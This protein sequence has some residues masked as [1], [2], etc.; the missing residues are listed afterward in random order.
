LVSVDGPTRGRQMRSMR[1]RS[2][3]TTSRR[4]CTKASKNTLRPGPT[5]A[6]RVVA[7][8][9]MSR[10]MVA[11]V[12]PMPATTTIPRGSGCGSSASWL[13]RRSAML[14]AKNASPMAVHPRRRL[15]DGRARPDQPVAQAVEE[16]RARQPMLQA[17]RRMG[18]FV[19]QVQGDARRLGQGQRD[20][21]GVSRAAGVGLDAAQ[22]LGH[23]GAAGA[24]VGRCGHT[25][26]PPDTSITAP[27]T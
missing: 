8:Y 24:V 19:L 12:P 6:S 17:A 13:N 5:T 25:V 22:R 14:L 7:R 23:P 2:L 4:P 26:I 16:Q 18:G 27:F 1:P 3:L 20:Q 21:V 15:D 11:E 10:L 9:R